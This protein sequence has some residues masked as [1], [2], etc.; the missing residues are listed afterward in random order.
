VAGSSTVSKTGRCAHS[1]REFGGFACGTRV[2]WAGAFVVGAVFSAAYADAVKAQ[3]VAGTPPATPVEATPAA[4]ESKS[5]KKGATQQ[6]DAVVVTAQK[7]K[8]NLKD[9]PISVSVMSGEQ[10]EAHHIT[11]YEDLTRAVPDLASSNGGGAGMSNIEMR[12]VSSNSGSATV[13]IYLDDV[14]MT[15]PNTLYIGSTEPNF[16]DIDQVEVLRGPQGTLYGA[17]SLG[18]TIKFSSKKPDSQIREA[19]AM[20]SVS[21]TDKG[22]ISYVEQGVLN[23]PITKGVSA[24]RIGVQY[25]TEA[26]YIDQLSPALA[27]D[28]VTPVPQTVTENDINSTHTLVLRTAYKYQASNLTVTPSVFYQRAAA[29][30]TDVFDLATF[31]Q[32]SKLVAEPSVDTFVVPSL[33]LDYNTGGADITSVSSFFWR[34]FTSTRD[35]TYYN[36]AYL[37]DILAA[38]KVLNKD[39]PRADPSPVA[40]LPGP[41]YYVPTVMQ[42]SEELRIASKSMKESGKP[43]TWLGGLYLAD[44]H[45]HLTDDEYINNATATIGELYSTRRN[46]VSGYDILVQN[47]EDP[48][49]AGGAGLSPEQAQLAA[50]TGDEVYVGATS[51]DDRQVSVFGEASYAP[52]KK[53]TLTGGLRYAMARTSIDNTAGGYYNADATPYL[54]STTHSYSL[55]PKF[56]A[57]YSIAKSASVYATA[58]KGFRLGGANGQI[59]NFACNQSEQDLGVSTSPPVVY[60]PDS[61]WSYEAGSKN[62][63]FGNRLS[64]DASVYYIDWK[65][66]QQ[67]IFLSCGFDYTVNAGQAESY[68]ADLAL[69]GKVTPHLTATLNGSTTHAVVTQAAV[70]S[71]AEAGDKLLGVPDWTMASGLSYTQA[72]NDHLQGFGNIDWS[73]VG[74]SHGAFTP[75]DLDYDRP[76]YG[77]LNA[78]LGVSFANNVDLSIFGK[79]LLNE[80]KI[81]QRPNRL[82][83]EQGYTLRPI[84]IGVTISAGF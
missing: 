51:E 20:S 28:G 64:V 54:S 38:D 69:R 44:Q 60:Q 1:G 19:S 43:Y 63:F 4:P 8:E 72:I 14:S 76:S 11:D 37:A 48:V 70:G 49:I 26:G 61:L 84:T 32:T 55:T 5:A 53:L 22:G 29:S 3:D 41:A 58:V 16:F 65:N 62:T 25:T 47:L 67:Q 35:G 73:M 2:R 82:A 10:L 17:S 77:T 39:Y 66:V 81:I 74:P 33:T 83:V 71:G 21:T 12:G 68:G 56:A 15:V 45:S 27:A 36:S 31:L 42:G 59:P 18:G 40:V 24:V 7:R 79:N 34:R 80:D 78:A 30:N 50:S 75:D 46:P 52:I 6:L 9:V 23:L 13:G 57:V